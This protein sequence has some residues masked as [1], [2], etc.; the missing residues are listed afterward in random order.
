MAGSSSEGAK[1]GGSPAIQKA[2]RG[3]TNQE[4]GEV[5]RSPPI[6]R[7]RADGT[8]IKEAARGEDRQQDREERQMLYGNT[9]HE[10]AD[11]GRIT[12]NTERKAGAIQIKKAQRRE[13][14]RQYQGWA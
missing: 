11:G 5:V 7:G 4:G 9:N 2:G 10:G 6:Q 1:R 14:R 3:Y 12:D 8:P 13:D